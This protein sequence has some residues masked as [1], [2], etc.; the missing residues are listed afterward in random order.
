ML[1]QKSEC[2]NHRGLA[3]VQRR[4]LVGNEGVLSIIEITLLVLHVG[5]RPMRD[6]DRNLDAP[7]MQF[8]KIDQSLYAL[9]GTLDVKGARFIVVIAGRSVRAKKRFHEEPVTFLQF[10]L[11]SAILAAS[12]VAIQR[13]Q[14]IT[15]MEGIHPMKLR[16][17][18]IIPRAIIQLGTHRKLHGFLSHLRITL[19][20]GVDVDASEQPGPQ[21]VRIVDSVLATY[22]FTSRQR[23]VT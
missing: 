10:L 20:R 15:S 22:R 9:R 14:D 1:V 3:P 2:C 13:F 21:H 4:G 17:Y 19:F 16:N 6:F 8:P 11:K 18:A 7:W 12:D 5:N 23:D